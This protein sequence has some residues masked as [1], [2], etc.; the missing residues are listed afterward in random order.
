MK[1]IN[2]S[3]TVVMILSIFLVSVFIYGCGE[4]KT[5]DV[6]EKNKVETKPEVNK[7]SVSQEMNSGNFMHADIQL[8]SMQCGM[9]KKTIETAV[10]NTEGVYSIN[11]DKDQKTAHVDYDK[12]I[13]D[14]VKIESVITAAGYDANDKKADLKAYENLDDCC[15]LPKDQKNKK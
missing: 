15:K 7:E 5:S 14:I 6:T 9:C 10:S 8:S 3:K 12:E 4:N 1:H 11:V 13:I 2:L